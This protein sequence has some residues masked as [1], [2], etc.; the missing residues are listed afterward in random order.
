MLGSANSRQAAGGLAPHISKLSRSITDSPNASK[1][2]S[3][4][5]LPAY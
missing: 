4:S 3:L 1:L 2:Q 5:I